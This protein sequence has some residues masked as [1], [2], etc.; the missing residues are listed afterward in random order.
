MADRSGLFP[1][2][3]LVALLL[4]PT[5]GWAD[6][7]VATAPI[8]PPAPPVVSAPALPT[9]P[10]GEPDKPA[11]VKPYAAKPAAPKPATAAVPAKRPVRSAA[12]PD[13]DKNKSAASRHRPSRLPKQEKPDKQ[14]AAVAA[15]SPPPRH[16][17]A[18]RYY[19]GIP[20]PIDGPP[21]PPPWYDRDPSFGGYYPG[22]WRR[23]PM[24]W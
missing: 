23:G 2:A 1:T 18:R 15:S 24:P 17:P 22:P 16:K 19:A 5:I 6:E 3:A 11:F 20:A 8:P 9:Q 14:H 7:P 21:I 10:A 4:A 13:R 12:R